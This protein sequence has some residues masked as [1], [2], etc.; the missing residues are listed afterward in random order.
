M[1]YLKPIHAV[2]QALRVLFDRPKCCDT[3]TAGT[4]Y[5]LSLRDNYQRLHLVRRLNTYCLYNYCKYVLP[6]M[7]A[8]VLRS[9]GQL[10]CYSSRLHIFS[11][12]I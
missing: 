11:L 4:V 9:P 6:I 2:I 8:Q 3:R 1:K 12:G 10:T 7:I 5:L